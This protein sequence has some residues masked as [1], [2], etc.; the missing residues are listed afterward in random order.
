MAQSVSS[1]I[2]RRSAVAVLTFH[3]F[4]YLISQLCLKGVKLDKTQSEYK[5]SAS[6]LIADVRADIAFRR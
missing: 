1:S 2:T 6:P 5:E 3:R 4:R